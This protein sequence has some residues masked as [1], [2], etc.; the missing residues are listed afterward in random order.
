M[1]QNGCRRRAFSLV[2]LLVVISVLSLLMGILL[3][4]F[5]RVRRKSRIL[6]G[7][8]NQRRIVTA[9]GCYALDNKGFYPESVATITFGTTWHWQ[10]PT[11]MTACRPRPPFKHRSVSAYLLS[12]ISEA[13]TMFCPN[14]PNKYKYLEQVWEAGD[15]WDNPETSFL[16]DPFF[17]TYCFYWNYVGFLG[18]GRAPFRGPRDTMGG[19]SDLLVSDYFGYGHHRSPDSYGS[20]EKFGDASITFGSEVSS[21][22]WSLSNSDGD[23]PLES[24][25]IKLHAG[26]T[27]GH[28][29]DFTSSQV[30][31]MKVSITPDGSIP[32]PD[33]V[34]LGPGDFYLPE[35]AT[36]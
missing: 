3:P 6:L 15:D 34:G 7:V 16:D 21:A 30:I 18:D 5:S 17:G 4:V 10:E 12:Y 27:D 22:Y 23:I 13:G 9:L 2:E 29:E 31:P 1:E 26:F 35:K 24:L 32:Y 14:A 28:V 8:N 11:M 19:Q 25:N 36:Y 20:C 33:G